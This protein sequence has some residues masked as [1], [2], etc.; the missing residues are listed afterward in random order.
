[1]RI[2]KIESYR[3]RLDD[4]ESELQASMATVAGGL[5][6]NEAYL[7]IFRRLEKEHESVKAEKAALERA[8]SFRSIDA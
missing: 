5:D 4:L 2:G 1:M 8:R 3:S 7:P 6:S